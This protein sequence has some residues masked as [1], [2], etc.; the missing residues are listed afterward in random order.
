[1]SKYFP[2]ILVNETSNME[3]LKYQDNSNNNVNRDNHYAKKADL[4]IIQGPTG[5][6][7]YTGYTGST[8]CTGYTGYIGPTVYIGCIDTTGYTGCTCPTGYTR[9]L[10]TIKWLHRIHRIH[11]TIRYKRF[12]WFKWF[13]WF[14]WFN[15]CKWYESLIGSWNIRI[16]FFSWF[17]CKRDCINLCIFGSI[18][19]YS[20]SQYSDV[21]L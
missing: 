3:D 8:G 5:H 1:M 12:I 11:R 10:H 13:K 2:S 7:G 17:N 16:C 4:Q 20:C 21:P 19:I 18:S 15:R 14:K 6:T 9:W